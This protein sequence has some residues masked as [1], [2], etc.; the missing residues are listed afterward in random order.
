MNNPEHIVSDSERKWNLE[1]FN[2][3]KVKYIIRYDKDKNQS[4]ETEIQSDG[5]E[6]FYRLLIPPFSRF[7]EKRIKE[8][9]F[10]YV[11]TYRL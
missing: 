5:T 2:F 3:G 8:G 11:K 10:G 4:Y 7:I 6:K 9:K 1:N